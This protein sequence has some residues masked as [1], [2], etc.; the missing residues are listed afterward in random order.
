MDWLV[1]LC[2]ALVTSDYTEVGLVSDRDTMN[3][4]IRIRTRVIRFGIGNCLS[5]EFDTVGESVLVDCSSL[6]VDDI[7]SSQ[8]HKSRWNS[9]EAIKAF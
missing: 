2:K 4:G 9:P 3:V 1:Y 5:V 8:V 6:N 7:S